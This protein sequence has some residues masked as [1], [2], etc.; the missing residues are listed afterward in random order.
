MGPR[1]SWAVLDESFLRPSS[2]NDT[3]IAND[4][5]TTFMTYQDFAA[6]A[7]SWIISAYVS[8][9][10]RNFHAGPDIIWRPSHVISTRISLSF[11]S[12]QKKKHKYYIR[13]QLDSHGGSL[14]SDGSVQLFS[15]EC[16]FV[17]QVLGSRSRVTEN[18]D[19][20][21]ITQRLLHTYISKRCFCCLLFIPLVLTNHH[22]LLLLDACRPLHSFIYSR[23]CFIPPPQSQS[24]QCVLRQNELQCTPREAR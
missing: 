15:L 17:S 9:E 21:C 10:R 16:A 13:I 8:A 12:F 4:S 18:I 20:A 2:Q 23:H 3:T 14:S 7:V 1:S 22:A 5:K 6:P 24:W 11:F 19:Y